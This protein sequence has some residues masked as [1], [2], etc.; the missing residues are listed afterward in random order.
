ML[1]VSEDGI[2]VRRPGRLRVLHPVADREDCG[3]RRLQK[4]PEAQW[5]TDPGSQVIPYSQKVFSHCFK[6]LTAVKSENR[7]DSVICEQ[8]RKDHLHF[9]GRATKCSVVR[10][11]HLCLEEEFDE[12][13]K[14]DWEW[15]LEK[16][17]GKKWH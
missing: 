17:D 10:H 15:D 3:H 14:D 11:D 8:R 9:C 2:E 4:E 16:C 1:C 13:V 5:T 7:V 6:I 12:V